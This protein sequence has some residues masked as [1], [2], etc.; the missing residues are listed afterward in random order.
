M[1]EVQQEGIN[2]SLDNIAE[3]WVNILL[4]QI[5]SKKEQEKFVSSNTLTKEEKV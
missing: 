5:R 4:A 3:M 2:A 1:N